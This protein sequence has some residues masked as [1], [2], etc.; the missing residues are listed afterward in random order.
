MFS[1]NFMHRDLKPKNIVL[2]TGENNK[3]IVKITDFGFTKETIGND[4]IT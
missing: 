2:K 4:L 1:K 3:I